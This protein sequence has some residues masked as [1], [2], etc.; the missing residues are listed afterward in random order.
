MIGPTAALRF[1]VACLALAIA[2]GEVAGQSAARFNPPKRYYLALGD[3]LAF[4]FQ[5][6][7]F[8]ASFPTVPASIFSTGYVD[9]FAGMLQEIRPG[10]TT[11]NYGC[12]GETS[13]T[14]IQGGCIYTAAG[15]PLHDPYDGSQLSAA[16]QFLHAH[17][18]QVSPITINLGTNDLNALTTLCGSDVSCYFANGP[19][20]LNNIANNLDHILTQLR[21]AAPDA[22]II[23]F[24]HYSVAPLFD[25]RLLQL[26][27]AFNSV[28]TS[29]AAAASARVA[30]VFGAFN[31][32]PQPTTLC[33]LTFVCTPLQD[34]HPT[35]LGY[36]VI[37]QQIWTASD[38][39]RLRPGGGHQF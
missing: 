39:D 12:S 7:K 18:G 25:P 20:V 13:L 38:Y 24:T 26:T 2:T 35:D 3:S 33:A 29:T 8:N 34:S 17:R 23:T 14:F 11:V 21:A 6:V 30:D 19:A 1:A 5:F 36:E 9:A 31:S 10:V 16:L 22:E 37:A 28:V 32:G 15:F 4:G 27:D